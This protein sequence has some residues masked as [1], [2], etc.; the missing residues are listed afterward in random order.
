MTNV[1]KYLANW[2]QEFEKFNFP[3]YEEFPDF[4]LYMEQMLGLLEKQ[5]SIYQTS[6]LDKQISPSMIN[7]YVKGDVVPS[8]ITKKYNREH[9]SA[10]DEVCVLKQVLP[11][12][13]VKQILDN[14]YKNIY[15][16]DAF[17]NFKDKYQENKQEAINYAN[18]K[19]ENIPSDDIARLTNLS[20][21]LATKAEAY[22]AISKRI[23]FFLRLL[24]NEKE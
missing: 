2:L 22:I 13:E 5:L 11:L 7:N 8:P 20:L 3:N 17:N 15:R 24:Q 10:I 14:S 9:F 12:T 21:D 1:N 19:L 16:G 6:T 23:L 18:E 4:E